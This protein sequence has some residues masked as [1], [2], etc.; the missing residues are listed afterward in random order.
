MLPS[1]KHQPL[2]S[3]FFASD[4]VILLRDETRR[5]EVEI[6]DHEVRTGVASMVATSIMDTAIGSA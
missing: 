1:L 4:S 2:V 3:T 5:H 6:C